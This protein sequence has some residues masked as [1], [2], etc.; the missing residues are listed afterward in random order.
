MNR[1]QIEIRSRRDSARFRIVGQPYLSRRSGAKAG[2][3]AE[4]EQAERLRY[5]SLL[6]EDSS[7]D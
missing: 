2:S 4:G 5:K 6:T 1:R 7:A 3:V